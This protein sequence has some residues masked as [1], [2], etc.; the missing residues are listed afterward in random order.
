MNVLVT[1]GCGQLGRE[2]GLVGAPAGVRYIFSDIAGRDGAVRL[3]VTD[4]EE[5]RAV[6]ARERIDVIVNCA[7]YTDVE[8]AEAD[9]ARADLLNRAAVAGM[10]SVAA[11]L[12]IF[13]MH[14][15]TDYVFDG[16]SSVPYKET[17]VPRPLNVYGRTKLAG[18]RAVAAS[19]CCHVI[20]RTQWLYS[21]FGRNFLL[22][23]LRVM[24][25][26]PQMRVVSDQVGAPTYAADL[27]S[28]IARLLGSGMT[29]RTGASRQAFALAGGLAGTEAPADT[30]RIL[31]Y[32]DEGSCSWYDFAL[33]IREATGSGCEIM[34]CTSGE[35][36][37]RAV[38]PRYSVLDKSLVRETLGV[39]V[40][41]WRDSLLSCL[42]RISF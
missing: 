16:S 4:A 17:D 37:S 11:E 26:R 34:P 19:G 22:T 5:L 24:R 6:C 39:D 25:D 33:A 36:G 42:R 2:I 14:I 21:P 8:R 41:Q 15:S 10:A 1:G 3:D 18:E 38:R 9:E 7:A 13:L 12:D 32:S 35:Y 20:I 28:F 29:A 27:A 23:A 31:H 40:P 30:G